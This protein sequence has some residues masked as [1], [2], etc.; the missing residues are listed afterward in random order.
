VV[1]LVI[2]AIDPAATVSDGQLVATLEPTRLEDGPA[3]LRRH[4]GPEAVRLGSLAG[5]GLVR[6]LHLSLAFRSIEA[7]DL[8]VAT[9]SA[10]WP[11]SA[12]PPM[13]GEDRASAL[14]ECLSIG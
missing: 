10:R 4:P 6:A 7:D 12:G 13:L 3:G 2:G 5:V 9:G 1:R 8:A 11:A 14:V